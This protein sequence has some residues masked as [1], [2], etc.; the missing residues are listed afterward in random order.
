[1]NF[2]NF[3]AEK[4]QENTQNLKFKIVVYG[5]ID[6]MKPR[7]HVSLPA[8][9]L[10]FIFAHPLN[11][12]AKKH[13]TPTPTE[14][15]TETPTATPTST[16]IPYTGPK[17]YTFDAMWG[18]KGADPD[19]LNAPEGIDI[20][21][22]GKIVIADTGNSRIVVWDE[23]GKPVTTLGSFGSRADWRNLPQ[24]NHPAG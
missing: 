17:I 9:L 2:G 22:S 4:L 15:F 1:M 24:F 14:T 12:W 13:H 6:F 7:Y 10:L 19:Q 5:S 16:P 21:P 23:N 18:S 20:S 11:L 8:F 3:L